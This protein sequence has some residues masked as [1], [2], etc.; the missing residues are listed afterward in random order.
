MPPPLSQILMK[1][2]ELVQSAAVQSSRTS[3]RIHS[4]I[5]RQTKEIYNKKTIVLQS[6]HVGAQLVGAKKINSY[7]L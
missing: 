1:K 2:E 7:R 6:K 3:G 5:E 4:R